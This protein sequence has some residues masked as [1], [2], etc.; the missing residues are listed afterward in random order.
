MSSYVKSILLISAVLLLVA[1]QP[2][3]QSQSVPTLFP[4]DE[5]VAP[6]A[7]SPTETEIPTEPPAPTESAP[8]LPPTWTPTP[9]PTFTPAPPTPTATPVVTVE[10]VS[11]ACEVFGPDRTRTLREFPIGTAPQVFWIPVEGA[12]TYRIVLVDR[13][14]IEI[15]EEYV[16]ETTY[17]FS[18]DLFELGKRYGWE[19]YP[20]DNLNVQ[21]C[22]GRGDELIPV[23]AN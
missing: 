18:A 20:R 19:V 1:C 3:G 8:Q 23:A 14:G 17:T 6:P 15:I 10:G 22:Y 12:L 13:F 4:T 2:Q 21:M 11:E 9:S 5:P 7:E 16:A